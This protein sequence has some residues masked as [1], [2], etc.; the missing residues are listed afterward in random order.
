MMAAISISHDDVIDVEFET[1]S[2]GEKPIAMP[3]AKRDARA[4]PPNSVDQLSLLRE[5]FAD[6]RATSQ[7]DQLS[8][9]FL[10]VTLVC[11]FFVFW[12][13]GGHALLY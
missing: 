8:P 4:T 2:S 1:V 11:A 13:S 6:P 3:L 12:V 5:Q 7:P 9:T 10:F